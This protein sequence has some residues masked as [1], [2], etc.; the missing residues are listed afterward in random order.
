MRVQGRE[1][2]GRHPT[3]G[4]LAL[5]FQRARRLNGLHDMVWVSGQERPDRRVSG[6]GTLTSDE[7]A[8]RFDW[9]GKAQCLPPRQGREGFSTG[10]RSASLEQDGAYYA[11]ILRVA[12]I[13]LS[14]RSARLV[15]VVRSG[16]VTVK[17]WARAASTLRRV[18]QIYSRSFNSYVIEG[19]FAGSLN[20]KLERYGPPRNG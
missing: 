10:G 18:R 19:L 13:H 5:G 6:A 1:S 3:G 2:P 11:H 16:R 14:T 7:T 17:V 15:W 8:V 4:R 12:R 20:G 9:R